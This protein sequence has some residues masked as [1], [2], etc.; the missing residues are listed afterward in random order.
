MVRTK[1]DKEQIV[2]PTSEIE[3]I[4]VLYELGEGGQYEIIKRNIFI[5][6]NALIMGKS[7]KFLVD[8]MMDKGVKP[9]ELGI[10]IAVALYRT[11]PSQLSGVDS[12]I[13]VKVMRE[14]KQMLEDWKKLEVQNE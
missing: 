14:N 4:K 9:L 3:Q 7:S 5:F 2:V 11:N 6:Q 12:S 8:S 1:K 13:R 10:S